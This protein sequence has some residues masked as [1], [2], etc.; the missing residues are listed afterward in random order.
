MSQ[1]QSLPGDPPILKLN[2]HPP[3]CKT[4][5][6][7]SKDFSNRGGPFDE[8]QSNCVFGF[9]QMHTLRDHG[10]LK[11]SLSHSLLHMAAGHPDNVSK[12][13]TTSPD[14]E[15][16]NSAIPKTSSITSLNPDVLLEI[17][18][19]EC[20][21]PAS[22]VPGE[23]TAPALVFSQVCK[24]WRSLIL[25]QSILWSSLSWGKKIE[26]NIDDEGEPKE[27]I[28]ADERFVDL[29][30]L[31]LSRS[32]QALLDVSLQLYDH[33][34]PEVREHLVD[35]IFNQQNRLKRFRLFCAQGTLPEGNGYILNSAPR[36]EVLDIKVSEFDYIFQPVSQK[37]KA[38]TVDMSGFSMLQE[39]YLSGDVFVK[40]QLNGLNL[41]QTACMWPNNVIGAGSPAPRSLA[42]STSSLFQFL[43]TARHLHSMNSVIKLA[44]IVPPSSQ[45]L[46]LSHLCALNLVMYTGNIEALD[47]LLGNLE[48]P[49]LDSLRLMFTNSRGWRGPPGIHR[50]WRL[51][52]GSVLKTVKSL[53]LTSG[54]FRNPVDD[55]DIRTL[56]Q[57]TPAL[58]DLQIHTEDITSQVLLLLTLQP[59]ENA[60]RN[61]CT[62]LEDL[63]LIHDESTVHRISPESIIDLISSR[64]R[65]TQENR[66]EMV[67]G[68]TNSPGMIYVFLKLKVADGQTD[69]SSIEPIRS[70]IRQGLNFRM[71]SM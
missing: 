46:L 18:E 53:T 61:L 55:E 54:W 40:E 1:S 22:I 7:Q 6:D 51:T 31:Y 69:L 48:V 4:K 50:R 45:R 47:S 35:S 30:N 64:W 63:L 65:P 20:S 32:G 11:T 44:D 14:L 52:N 9:E 17:F 62:R 5:C 23:S 56:L 25:A 42:T 41:L 34:I 8:A 43:N 28:T 21:T 66:A 27:A 29:W 33:D 12:S 68:S 58:E 3:F 37:K 49:W 39:V 26:E 19:H 36:L 71:L 16:A 15:R 59:L 67:S 10:S 57:C 38:I 24:S 13:D 2:D 60:S 70:F